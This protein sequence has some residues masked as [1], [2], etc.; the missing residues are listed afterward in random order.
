ML[1][2]LW[3]ALSC[4]FCATTS[5]I[6][7]FSQ[8][9]PKQIGILDLSD[10]STLLNQFVSGWSRGPEKP[11]CF[12][13]LWFLHFVAAV[14]ICVYQQRFSE[15]FLKCPWNTVL[16]NI[17]L[18]RFMVLL[19][20]QGSKVTAV[21]CWFSSLSLACKDLSWFLHV[22]LLYLAESLINLYKIIH[23]MMHKIT[24]T[25]W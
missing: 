19:S 25:G 14:G 13:C 12:I 3:S 20:M 11:G 8:D 5:T 17:R 23:K 1:I 22:H 24:Y 4:F 18:Y 10:R 16:Y 6:R 15:V 2:S 21:K 9:S 7:M